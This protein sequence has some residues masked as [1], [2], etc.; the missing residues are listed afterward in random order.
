MTRYAAHD[1]L[2]EALART[3]LDV[4]GVAFLKPGLTDLLRSRT[5]AEPARPG[6]RTA[7]IRVTRREESEP[8]EVDVRIV[9]RKERRSVDVARA[10]RQAV[11]E[12]LAVLL[13]DGKASVRVTVTGLV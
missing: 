11:E 3:V 9:A 4:P 7:G 12:S 10:T 8:W 5:G 2:T 13:P 6:A 1:T